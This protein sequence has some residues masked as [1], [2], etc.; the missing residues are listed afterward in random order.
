MRSKLS[1][2][3]V[4]AILA[5]AILIAPLPAS[6]APAS[7][8]TFESVVAWVGGL[9]HH[10]WAEEGISIDPLGRPETVPALTPE[11]GRH[12]WAEEGVSIDPFGLTA[13]APAATAEGGRQ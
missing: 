12:L 11:G 6:A 9:L 13:P 7:G 1:R 5:V 3:L 2:L 8:A 4:F 10:L